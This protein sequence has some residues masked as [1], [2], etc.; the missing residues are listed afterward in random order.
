MRIQ[1]YDNVDVL[2]GNNGNAYSGSK[3][4][5][6]HIKVEESK[7]IAS[8][9][10]ELLEAVDWQVGEK[11]KGGM[12][13]F[14]TDVNAVQQSENKIVD[15]IKKKAKTINN[16]LNYTKK[17]DKVSQENELIGWTLGKFLNGRY[18][19]QKTQKPFGENSLSLELVGITSDALLNIATQICKDFDQETVLVKDYNTGNIYFVNAVGAKERK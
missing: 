13:I 19:S 18:V 6:N 8:N 5:Y 7:I 11:E 17:V 2:P 12:I 16:R 15:W 3:Y 1:K 4:L 10:Q 14:S 9:R